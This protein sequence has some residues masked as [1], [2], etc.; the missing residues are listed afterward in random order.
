M[1]G[2][3]KTTVSILLS[4]LIILSTVFLAEAEQTA[5]DSAN[6]IAGTIVV[7]KN[8]IEENGFYEA[9]QKALNSALGLEDGILVV[10][11]EPGEYVLE[12]MLR[13][14]ANTTLSLHDVVIKR[15]EEVR[16]N[17]L[18]IGENDIPSRGP[19]GYYYEN[20][21]IDGGVFDA[22]STKGTM[23][24]IVHAKNFT[25]NNVTLENV[26]NSHI[27]EVAGV[28][29]FNLKGC[30]FIN[31]EQE[32][33]QDTTCYEAVQLDILR[34]SNIVNCRSEDLAMK[35]V[36]VEDCVFDKCPRGIGSH[37]A[38]L[39][40]PF[41]NIIIK[42]NKFTNM[43]S[44][45]IQTMNWKNCQITDNYIENT[46]RAI[47]VYST[48]SKGN[49]MYVASELAEEGDT[50]A[51]V[52]DEF[53]EPENSNTLIAYNTI[54]NCG[55][56]QD[57]LAD[58][59]PSAISLIGRQI[60]KEDSDNKDKKPLPAGYYYVN[61]VCIRDNIVDVKGAACRVEHSRNVSV[62]SNVFNCDKNTFFADKSYNGIN[63]RYGSKVERLDNNRVNNPNSSGIYVNDNSLVKSMDNNT[64][65]T[66][67]KYGI[68]VYYSNV[69]SLTG[70]NV[71]DCKGT[72]IMLTKHSAARDVVSGNRVNSC[73]IGIHFSKDSA[74]LISGNTMGNTPT[75]IKYTMMS[76]SHSV[77]HNYPSVTAVSNVLTDVSS[78]ELSEGRT[79]KLSASTAPVNTSLELSY[80]SSDEKVAKVDSF[81]VITAVSAGK[82]QITAKAA[83]GKSASVNVTVT[84]NI[85]DTKT[86]EGAEFTGL[87]SVRNIR[88]GVEATWDSVPGA[89]KYQVYR[90]VANANGSRIA[91]TTATSY[92]DK[93]VVSGGTYSYTV[94]AV[95]KSG[96]YI[97][98]FDGVGSSITYVA[99]TSIHRFT[100]VPGKIL[101]NWNKINGAPCYKLY[102]R[103]K[104]AGWKSLGVTTAVSKE[105]K[106]VVSGSNYAFIPISL[107]RF[108]CPLNSF[109]RNG[110]KTKYLAGT[111]LKKKVSGK[112]IKLSWKKTSGAKKYIVYGKTAV[113][114]W[115]LIKVVKKNSFTFKGKYKTSYNFLIRCTDSTVKYASHYSN[116]V[117]AKVKS[118]AQIKREKLLKKLKEKKALEKA[119]KKAQKA[120]AQAKKAAAVTR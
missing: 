28:D 46:P 74:G 73:P 39:N 56:V 110:L 18:R 52:S 59:S 80:S 86:T 99:P 36:L 8:D 78:V 111:T 51:H 40:N 10:K 106:G 68:G 7:T 92:V 76:T 15:T 60:T 14:Y 95:D 118:K 3:L 82:A 72:G 97:G 70:N 27:M 54:K 20:I 117:S 62:Y 107:D 9:V 98:N 109:D 48:G 31:Q 1:K 89:V 45:A 114:N 108:G 77:G 5:P 58:Y 22:A 38:V 50:E 30:S 66:A 34:S 49:G 75:M 105:L 25:M 19:K 63:I 116:I 57:I 24:K 113:S 91:E 88:Y 101:V 100:N 87:C 102:Y 67:K 104:N 35:N 120:A 81:G 79:Y 26:K 96:K 11:V 12:D 16:I 71:S 32:L 103:K 17:M 94:R 23:F 69:Y 2:L 13:I 112:K 43:M 6:P 33:N 29:G 85:K 37:T 84:D 64:V 47:A 41:D 61:G 21:T 55:G 93:Y 53:K 44:A 115:K 42:N 90:R 83:S 4:V 65:K 119:K